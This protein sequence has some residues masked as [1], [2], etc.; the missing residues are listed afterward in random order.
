MKNLGAFSNQRLRVVPEQTLETEPD[1]DEQILNLRREFCAVCYT[2]RVS[3]RADGVIFCPECGSIS[4]SRD[5]TAA[6]SPGA[7]VMERPES[8]AKRKVA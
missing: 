4:E 1:S 3:I 5:R 2:D 7:H 6:G 8:G